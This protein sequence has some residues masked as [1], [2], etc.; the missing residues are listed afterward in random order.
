[1]S[2]FIDTSGFLAL[3]NADDI[4]HKKADVIWRD[5]IYKGDELVCS[6][7]ILLET[8]T[9]IQNRIGLNAVKLFYENVIPI[10]NVYWVNE[11]LHNASVTNLLIS[12]R[13]KL[14]LVDCVSFEVM[15]SLGLNN[16]FAFDK[17]FNEQG[18]CCL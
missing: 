14:S 18:F 2:I 5:L 1:M 3:I 17:H 12:N 6:N 9:L 8:I 13:K 11:S 4:N 7:Y 16:V 15:K 10:V